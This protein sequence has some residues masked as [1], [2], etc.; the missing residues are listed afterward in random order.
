MTEEERKALVMLANLYTVIYSKMDEV[1]E[2]LGYSE[3][4]IT[5]MEL[6]LDKY[7]ERN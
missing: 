7:K 4:E 1:L 5:E 6:A 2:E 3:D